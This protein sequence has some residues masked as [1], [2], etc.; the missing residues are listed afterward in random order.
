M[1]IYLGI[2]QVALVLAFGNQILE[3]GLLLYNVAHSAETF[4]MA[5]KT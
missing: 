1:V 5:K 4:K 2:G 3:A